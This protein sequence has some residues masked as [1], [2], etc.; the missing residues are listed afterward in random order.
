[1]FC[2]WKLY[3]WLIWPV[4][5]GLGLK[6]CKIFCASFNM[7]QASTVTNTLSP[8]SEWAKMGFKGS[9]GCAFSL[10]PSM[11]HVITL[12]TC[13]SIASCSSYN[14]RPSMFRHF[15]SVHFNF[16]WVEI[17]PLFQPC[18][19]P[20]VPSS[21]CSCIISGCR[22]STLATM[23]A[24]HRSG[25]S[26]EQDGTVY[27]ASLTVSPVW[28][29][30]STMFC[31]LACILHIIT[32]LFPPPAPWVCTVCVCVSV[33]QGCTFNTCVFNVCKCVCVSVCERGL[34]IT[35]A[36]ML[37]AVWFIARTNT[38]IRQKLGRLETQRT[39]L[40]QASAFRQACVV[41]VVT[42]YIRRKNT[43]EH[44]GSHSMAT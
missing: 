14:T 23:Q 36:V 10:D 29:I 4:V 6:A 1:M 38:H 9:R 21:L 32:L 33:C 27:I 7:W 42:G 37:T 17:E 40:W 39:V 44:L 31:Q 30:V 3:V 11:L 19:L 13:P 16:T 41:L 26:R 12:K 24:M 15:V 8:I 28:C 5:L 25:D 34:Y 2:S 18:S 20:F 43:S 35:R 22:L